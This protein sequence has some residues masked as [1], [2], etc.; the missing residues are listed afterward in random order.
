MELCGCP[1]KWMNDY[2]TPAASPAPG[3][4][5]N[6]L[7]DIDVEAVGKTGRFGT[8]IESLRRVSMVSGQNLA[9]AAVVTG[10]LTLAAGLTGRDPIK[11]FTDNPDEAKKGIESAVVFLLKVV[12]VYCQLEPDIIAVADKPVPAL[13]TE[14]LSWLESTLSPIINTVRFY[15]SF[16]VLLTGEM[17]PDSLSGL[18][19]LGFDGI[20]AAGIDV[21][22]WNEIKGGRRCC[23][24][25]AIPSHVL[26]SPKNELQGYLDAN[27]SGGSERGVFLTTDWEVPPDT[28]SENIN[29]VMQTLS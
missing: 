24:G 23:L 20:V 8:V 15:N 12:Q 2:E 3:F 25:K 17:P 13:P 10:P 18:I 22:T 19:D 28:P 9:L 6:R 16:S 29:L 1:V 14:H 21:A 7:K 5:F 27:F 26:A 11:D 4:D